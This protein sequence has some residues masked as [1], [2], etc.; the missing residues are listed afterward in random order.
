MEAGSGHS[1]SS[2]VLP[3]KT[4]RVAVIGTG[5]LSHQLHGDRFGHMNENWDQEFLDLIEDDPEKLTEIHPDIWMERG[6][7]ESVEMIM[8][9]AMR[10]ALTSEVNKIHRSYYMPMLTGMGITVL[11]DQVAA[12]A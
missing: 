8:W 3:L 2:G 1:E 4:P 11:E 7:A 12:A 10:G 9:L 5:G 6:G